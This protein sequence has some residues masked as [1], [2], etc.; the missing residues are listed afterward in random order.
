MTKGRLY[1]I[2]F[3]ARSD[4]SRSMNVKVLDGDP[5]WTAYGL[6][7][8]V[9]LSPQWTKYQLFFEASGAS[10]TARLDF[11]CGGSDSSVELDQVEWIEI[12]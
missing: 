1:Q 10:A 12:S 4:L 9:W 11:L 5:P 6:N 7:E 2:S 3:Y 8:R